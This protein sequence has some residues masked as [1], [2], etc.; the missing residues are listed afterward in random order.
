MKGYLH[1]APPPRRL[2]PQRQ[3]FRHQRHAPAAGGPWRGHH[4]PGAVRDSLPL[5]R[6]PAG[7]FAA[8]GHRTHRVPRRRAGA[9]GRRK[10]GGTPC[11]LGAGDCCCCYFR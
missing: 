10:R 11:H 8:G 7:A 5:R 2:S 6:V 4:P 3:R 9:G 1:H